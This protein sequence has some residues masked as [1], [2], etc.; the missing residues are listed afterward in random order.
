MRALGAEENPPFRLWRLQSHPCFSPTP[1]HRA[2]VTHSTQP[3]N[4]QTIRR[5][6]CAIGSANGWPYASRLCSTCGRRPSISVSGS[7]AGLGRRGR[8]P[9]VDAPALSPAKMGAPLVQSVAMKELFPAHRTPGG[10]GRRPRRTVVYQS[11]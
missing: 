7:R 10:G 3:G 4:E 9:A 1:P 11:C 6:R 5:N 8:R 2:G